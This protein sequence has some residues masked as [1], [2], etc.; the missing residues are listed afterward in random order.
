MCYKYSVFPGALEWQGALARI[1]VEAPSIGYL[2]STSYSDSQQR[3][4]IS[5]LAS[6]AGLLQFKLLTE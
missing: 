6:A 1:D 2:N 5:L 4:F 3:A